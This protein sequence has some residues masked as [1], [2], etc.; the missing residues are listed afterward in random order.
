M[1]KMLFFNIC[2]CLYF[3]YLYTE[4]KAERTSYSLFVFTNVVRKADSDFTLLI[5]VR[6]KVLNIYLG[7]IQCSH[8]VI[9]WSHLQSFLTEKAGKNVVLS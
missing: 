8:S 5:T 4:H 7:N 1:N 3:K 9:I 6:K 2:T